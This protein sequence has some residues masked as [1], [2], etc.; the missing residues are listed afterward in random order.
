MKYFIATI[1]IVLIVV[2]LLNLLHYIEFSPLENEIYW[3]VFAV[4]MVLT[5]MGTRISKR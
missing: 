2:M 1:C 5:F 3:I 4:C